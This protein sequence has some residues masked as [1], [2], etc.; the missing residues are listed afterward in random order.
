MALNL[1]ELTR[2]WIKYLKN[3]RLVKG[4]SDPKT[5]KLIYIKQPNVQNLI[6]YLRITDEFDDDTIRVTIKKALSSKM[7]DDQTG[8]EPEPDAQ[9]AL[10][11]KEPGEDLST[12]H[13]NEM[14][15]GERQDRIP[16]STQAAQPQ[17]AQNKRRY[18]T[19][20]AQD[21]EVKTPGRVP[22][23]LG[24]P[25]ETRRAPTEQPPQTPPRKPRFKYRHR[26]QE[27]FYDRQGA[28]LSEDDIEAVFRALLSPQAGGQQQ[29]E[30]QQGETEQ[31][32]NEVT[33]RNQQHMRELKRMI[34][35]VMTPQQRKA[36]W[37]ALSEA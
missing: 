35:E 18:N 9:K 19:D 11:G 7:G 8:K 5:G 28:E 1:T 32:P 30:P 2:G 25:P 34:R 24:G 6:K 27:A 15:P 23:R 10:P 26:V 20:N 37:R 36:L 14:R 4:N 17:Q 31:D 22:P 29:G 13:H 33:A 3:N 12:W 21:V 16:Q